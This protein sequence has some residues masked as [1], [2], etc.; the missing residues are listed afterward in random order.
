MKAKKKTVCPSCNSDNIKIIDYLGVK[1]IICNNCGLDE[2][3]QYEVFPEE[4]KS[5]K[6]KGRYTPY[7]AGGFKRARKQ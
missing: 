1:C 6:E 7:K 4:N 3:K 2:S 5:Q